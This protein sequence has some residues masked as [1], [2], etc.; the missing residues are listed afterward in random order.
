MPHPGYV[1]FFLMY[2][3]FWG[4]YA[5][6]TGLFHKY[7]HAMVVC[8]LHLPITYI[9]HFSQSYSSSTSPLPAFPPLAPCPPTDPSVWCSP[10]CAYVFSLFKT[11]LWVRTWGVWFSVLVSVCWERCF[12]DS[13]M[14]LQ[15]TWTHPCYGCIVFHSVYMPH[16]LCSVYHWWTF[17]LVPSLC[18]CKQCCNEHSCAC[19]LIVE[20]F[21]VL[22]IYTQ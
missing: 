1:V 17:G 19:V 20:R 13:S 10:P 6:V 14:S 9:R 7:T 2:F 15:R 3:K 4:T 5:D 18:Y 22:W 11:Y 21:I 16:F 8:C 12:P